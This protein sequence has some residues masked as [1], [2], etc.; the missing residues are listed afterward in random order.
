MKKATDYIPLEYRIARTVSYT[1][2]VGEDEKK[3][4]TLRL[5]LYDI[6]ERIYE[7]RTDGEI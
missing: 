1:Y 2:R 6:P 5:A 3:Y 4:L 7:D